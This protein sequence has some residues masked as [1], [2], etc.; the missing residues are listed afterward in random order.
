MRSLREQSVHTWLVLNKAQNAI[1]TRLSRQLAAMNLGDTDFR[2][3][4]ILRH[5]GP[6]PVNGIGP[7]VY[8]NS[9]S[10]S[11]AVDRLYARKLVTRGESET[12]RRIRI[13]SDSPRVTNFRA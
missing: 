8:L 4:E 2:V 11:V 3:L 13:V 9:G 5:K 6:M 7:K 1:G 10:I 12:D